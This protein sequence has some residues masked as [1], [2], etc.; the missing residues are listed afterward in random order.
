[1]LTKEMES[2]LT[3]HENEALAL[4]KELAQIPA[5]SGKEEQRARF[6]HDWLQKQ[7]AEGVYID[8][9]LN[10]IYPI[11]FEGSN[12]PLTAHKSSPAARSADPQK[13]EAPADTQTCDTPADTQLFERS[14]EQPPLEVFA[15]HLD[16][17][18]PDEEPLPLSERDGRLY[19]PGIGDDTACV[20]CLLLAAKFIARCEKEGRREAWQRLRGAE[21]PALLL[22]C[23]TGE[24]GLGNLRGVR[25]LCRV[26]GSQMQSFCSFDSTLSHI[27]NR[28]V[29]SQRFC[30][31]V[32]TKGG[33]SFRDFGADNAIEKLSG[34]IHQLY[35]LPLGSRTTCNVGTI[36]GGTTVNSIAQHAEML[37]EFR[38]EDRA[39]LEHAVQQFLGLLD[40]AR[41]HSKP[42]T[43]I[44]LDCLGERPCGE[45]VDPERQRKLT[46]LG[47][48]AIRAVTGKQP[49]LGSGSTDCNLPLSLGIPS[50]CIGC[51]EGRGAHTR[52]E[53]IETSSLKKG[54]RAA[55]E[56][57]FGARRS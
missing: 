12:T 25:E 35:R 6:C 48:A 19:C 21:A 49:A 37:C 22:A 11:G 36:S 44:S 42:G 32:D 46:S 13:T 26:Y 50:I 7:G 55:F 57:I 40:R 10:V 33:H 51:Y 23:N 14:A 1:M 9:A 15:A 53:Y 52:E 45:T 16:I 56:M 54:C 17:V 41:R 34:I 3:E 30:V 4:L 8:D 2:F 20:V 27:V 5:P 31:S 18:F 24:E 28:A 47:I 43:Q 39:C 38:S 29:G